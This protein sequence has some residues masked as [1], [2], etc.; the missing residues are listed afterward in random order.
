MKA[1]SKNSDFLDCN[2]LLFKKDSLLCLGKRFI[3]K[4]VYMDKGGF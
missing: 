1:T 4:G 3:Y 2:A